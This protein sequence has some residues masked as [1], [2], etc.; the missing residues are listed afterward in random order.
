MP[1][2]ILLLFKRELMANYEFIRL[3]Q[4]DFSHDMNGTEPDG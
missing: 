3:Q 4:K 1:S 2:G